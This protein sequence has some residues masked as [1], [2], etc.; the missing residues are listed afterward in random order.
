MEM[1]VCVKK[2]FR[3]PGGKKGRKWSGVWYGAKEK[4]CGEGPKALSWSPLDPLANLRFISTQARPG[5][6]FTAVHGRSASPIR[7]CSWRSWRA[8]FWSTSSSHANAGGNSQ[9]A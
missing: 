7:S 6:R 4:G 1:G 5:T 3:E 8:N 2:T 9:T